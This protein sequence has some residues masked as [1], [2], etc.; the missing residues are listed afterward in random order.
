MDTFSYV[1]RASNKG[2]HREK[3]LQGGSLAS[4][5]K[6][7]VCLLDTGVDL[8]ER[9]GQHL[10]DLAVEK[11]NAAIRTITQMGLFRVCFPGP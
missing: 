8:L 5:L 11:T 7:V 3:N 9:R 2:H 4:N 10:G 6:E 1:E